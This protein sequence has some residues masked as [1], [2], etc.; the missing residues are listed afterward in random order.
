MCIF[1][2]LQCSVEHPFGWSHSHVNDKNRKMEQGESKNFYQ[3]AMQYGTYLGA[4]WAIMYIMLFKSFASPAMSILGMA[5]FLASPFIALRFVKKFRM[6]ECGNYI[7]FPQAWTFL[8][9]MYI[10]ATLLST[11]T[12]FIYLNYID[13]GEYLVEAQRMFSEM[14]TMPS[15]DENTTNMFKTSY[16]MWAQMSAKE[17]TW[18]LLNN[19][20]TSSLFLPPIIAIFARRQ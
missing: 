4:I 20:I 3:H 1:A 13:N 9:C 14:M 7:R 16:D 6:E 17:M 19:N 12:N 2:L 18:A 10:C 11:L 5:L 15:N 8:F